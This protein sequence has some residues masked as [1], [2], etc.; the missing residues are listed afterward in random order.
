MSFCRR[1]LRK[2]CFCC[3]ECGTPIH[4]GKHLDRHIA[5]MCSKEVEELK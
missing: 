4:K 5:S 2:E 3:S 1:C